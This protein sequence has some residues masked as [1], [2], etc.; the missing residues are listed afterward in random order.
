MP[1]VTVLP[2]SQF[3]TTAPATIQQGTTFSVTVKAEDVTNSVVA[4]YN[5]TV[6]LTSGDVAA[7]L[8]GSHTYT[9]ADSGIF[10]F[11]NDITFNTVGIQ[12]LTVTDAANSITATMD[13]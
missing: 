8:P 10:T 3:N 11:S 7:V 9:I 12:T 5:G 2:V 1:C 13:I 6:V 4:S